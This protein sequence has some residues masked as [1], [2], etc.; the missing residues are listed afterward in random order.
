[1]IK[2][3]CKVRHVLILIIISHVLMELEQVQVLN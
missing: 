1:M 3:E 2:E